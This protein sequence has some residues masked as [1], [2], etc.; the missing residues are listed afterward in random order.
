MNQ[1]SLLQTICFCSIYLF[2]TF[3]TASHS[4]AAKE[5]RGFDLAFV[6][7]EKGLWQLWLAD[8]TGIRQ[9]EI[10]RS[11]VDIR[12]PCWSPDG[13]SIAYATRDGFLYLHHPGKEALRL[14]V[15]TEN[16]GEIA[17]S[18]DGKSFV[19]ISYTDP[20]A[21]QSE[22]WLAELAPTAGIRKVEKIEIPAGLVTYPCRDQET[23]SYAR[24]EKVDYSGVIENICRFNLKEQKEEILIADGFDNIQPAW[25]PDGKVLAYASNKKG[26]FDI[27]LWNPAEDEHVQLTSDPSMDQSPA[28][29]PDGKTIAF[30]SSRTGVPQVWLVKIKTK[31]VRQIG[32]AERGSRDPSWRK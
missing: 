27:W 16:N 24:L 23:I 1:R 29:S 32:F 10:T 22:L 31:Q 30:T 5:N 9:K 11:P 14:H 8:S 15:P 25:S 18:P 7:V 13:D 17:W 21:Y 3:F 6:A 28:W 12:N 26:N 20:R 19:Y 4:P 2:L